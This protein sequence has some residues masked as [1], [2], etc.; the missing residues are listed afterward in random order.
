MSDIPEVLF[1]FATG[2][3]WPTTAGGWTT[4]RA[5]DIQTASRGSGLISGEAVG[6]KRFGRAKRPQVATLAND[7]LPLNHPSLGRYARLLRLNPGGAISLYGL[8]WTAFW[9]GFCARIATRMLGTDTVSPIAGLANYHLRGLAALLEQ[10]FII[11]GY[12]GNPSAAHPWNIYHAPDFNPHGL[13]NRTASTW[14]INAREVYVFDHYHLGEG[15]SWTI[16][17]A[18]NYLLEAFTFAHGGGSTWAFQDDSTLGA[19]VLT[20]TRVHG[21]TLLQAISDLASQYRGLTWEIDVAPDNRPRLILSDWK[22]ATGTALDATAKEWSVEIIEDTTTAADH[23]LVL[24]QSPPATTLTLDY[25]TSGSPTLAADGWTFG[26]PPANDPTNQILKRFKIASSVLDQMRVELV[27]DV[28]DA[29]DGSRQTAADI[30]GG[31]SARGARLERQTGLAADQKV[32]T[33]ATLTDPDLRG[34]ARVFLKGTGASSW[35][36]WS[37]KVTISISRD[38]VRLILNLND[39]QALDLYK[40]LNAG[41]ELRITIGVR[42][43]AECRFSYREADAYRGTREVARTVGDVDQFQVAVGT[44]IAVNNGTLITAGADVLTWDSTGD[45]LNDELDRLASAQ[46]RARQVEV[47][48]SKTGLDFTTL[49]PRTLL[50]TVDGGPGAISVDANII[51]QGWD[52]VSHKT[53]WSNQRAAKGVE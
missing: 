43:H 2:T 16:S 27:R 11:D 49:P 50:T 40:V 20:P 3:A 22:P 29:Y 46:L 28:N 24:T 9:H 47:I 8:Q 52:F 14:T 53:S 1:Q 45:A 26:A 18:L 10:V 32:A 42:E 6:I 34:P 21:K 38:P 15:E 30:G 33:V 13:G 48:L 39:D 23:A 17:Q 35:E 19:Q 25:K 12:E 51:S 7:P 41:G 31:P 36:D 44:A 37:D 5:V 4:D